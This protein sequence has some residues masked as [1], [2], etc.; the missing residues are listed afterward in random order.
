MNIDTPRSSP[1]QVASAAP[2][3]PKFRRE[4]E[5]R[6]RDALIMAA[7][8]AIADS[9]MAGATVRNIA[10]RA[11]VTAGLIRHYFQTREGLM[12][13]A[14]M[15]V[16]NRMTADSIAASDAAGCDPAARLTAFVCASFRPPVLDP[17]NVAI[18]A[19]FQHAARTDGD[20]TA[21]HRL[22]NMA[23]R[24]RLEALIVALPRPQPDRKTLRAEAIACNAVIDGLWI[25]GGSDHS[26]FAPGE[27]ER[28]GMRT[29]SAILGI[30]LP[31]R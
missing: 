14:Y 31:V 25:E 11:G 21:A 1:A 28:I 17:R 4:P 5:S 2:D 6:R 12:R 22:T 20:L 30:D 24:A 23:Y 8:D 19:E 18:W 10:A 26:A 27:I 15:Q 9:G 7:L 3:G 13:A 29:V 16:M